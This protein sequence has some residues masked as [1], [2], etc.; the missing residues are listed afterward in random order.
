MGRRYADL[1]HTLSSTSK[2]KSAPGWF[3]DFEELWGRKPPAS[4]KHFIMANSAA[5]YPC[6]GQLETNVLQWDY[7]PPSCKG[8]DNAFA[9]ATK[10][11]QRLLGG[12]ALIA[13]FTGTVP[14]GHDGSG[15]FYFGGV[16][17]TQR[18]TPVLYW[19]H[20]ESKAS[21]RA[22]TLDA[23]AYANLLTE[24]ARRNAVDG[25]E[26]EKSLRKVQT[27]LSGSPNRDLGSWHRALKSEE[28]LWYQRCRW[29]ISL[30][31]D[32]DVYSLEEVLTQLFDRKLNRLSRDVWSQWV[33]R[34]PR[35]VPTALYMLFRSYLTNDEATLESLL[36]RCRSS[37]ARL[38]R[39][40]AASVAKLQQGSGRL[41]CI[42][43][44][45]QRKEKLLK[46]GLP[47]LCRLTP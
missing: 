6:L 46:L 16:Y 27:L 4:L 23:F 44:M 9:S 26:V 43:D 2:A 11:G 13:L 24:L 15:D 40:A 38:I 35:H 28:E 21:T 5:G 41:G 19:D 29:L 12:G 1:V 31:W 18:K 7:G 3:C 17:P 34:A 8:G 45:D 10:A 30:L 37:R 25:P 14:L 32:D 33:V 22:S 42:R 47:R 36:K 20:E 39:N